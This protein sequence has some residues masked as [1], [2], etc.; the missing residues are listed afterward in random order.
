MVHQLPAQTDP[1]RLRSRIR[2]RPAGPFEVA[3]SGCLGAILG[4]KNPK[5][6]VRC[7]SL[8][9]GALSEGGRV[10]ETIETDY[11]VIGAGAGGM[12]LTDALIDAD[13]DCDVVM[14]D[15]RHARGG[16]WN[17]SHLFVRLH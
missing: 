12:S 4:A 8:A 13:Q 3:V 15:R 17:D 11:L 9:R 14:V 16:H 7:W 2:G 10:V 5:P 6:F 1:L